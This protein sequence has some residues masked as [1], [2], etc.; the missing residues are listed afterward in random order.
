MLLFL[1]LLVSSLS[2]AQGKR[3]NVYADTI[4]FPD[5]AAVTLTFRYV[6]DTTIHGIIKLVFLGSK[7]GFD[8][9]QPFVACST[10]DQ[11]YLS[12]SYD[13]VK[14][15]NIFC[16]VTG[17][18]FDYYCLRLIRLPESP[19]LVNIYWAYACEIEF[20]NGD[21]VLMCGYSVGSRD[22]SYKPQY[23]RFRNQQLL[24]FNPAIRQLLRS[25]K[26]WQKKYEAERKAYFKRNPVH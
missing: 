5:T 15:K 22:N 9:L 6:N 26:K 7:K 1:L 24:L 14:V 18:I 10:Y 4:Y 11:S 3:W 2:S 16:E 21:G 8:T 19:W 17:S 23:L 13:S 20:I 12:H 25:N